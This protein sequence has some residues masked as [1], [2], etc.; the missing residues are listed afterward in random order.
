MPGS[1]ETSHVEELV[2]SGATGSGE[3]VS[4]L[5]SIFGRDTDSISYLGRSLF[6]FHVPLERSH[7]RY[8]T[9]GPDRIT[10]YHGSFLVDPATAELK[11]LT[12]VADEFPAGEAACKVEDTMDYHRVKIGNGELL[13]PKPLQWTCFLTRAS[14]P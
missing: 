9:N 3:F 5:M 12:V 14:S 1:L 6:A 2:K 10:G 4:Y 7:Y 8:H 11:R 13:L